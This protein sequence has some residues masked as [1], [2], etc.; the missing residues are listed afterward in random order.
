MRTASWPFSSC[1]APIRP[2]Q[3]SSLAAIQR[4]IASRRRTRP[5]SRCCTSPCQLRHCIR[6]LRAKFFRGA[7]AMSQ[8][9]PSPSKP[10]RE[11]RATR[12]LSHGFETLVAS[13][14][15][16]RE[17]TAASIDF[18]VVIVGTGY[19]GSVAA[20][21]LARTRGNKSVCVLERG[22]E[23]L[24]GSFPARMAELAGDVRFSTKESHH[25]RGRREGLYD[26]RIGNDLCALVASGV[27]GGSLI[28]AG[29]MAL[30]HEDVFGTPAWPDVFHKSGTVKKLLASGA[31]LRQRLGATQTVESVKGQPEPKKYT[32]LGRFTRAK[33]E[34]LFI[35][36]ALTDASARTFDTAAG[37]RI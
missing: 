6:R 1:A 33:V 30:P 26:V 20:A 4:P 14:E 11:D 18:D 15:G 24:P 16:D 7:A 5:V 37:V 34:P 32:A 12:W 23:H 17:R 21:E 36:V 25:P 8:E 22:R 10:T 27:G 13:L 28:N 19:G 3:P 35:T 9:P 29:V 2:C 31:D